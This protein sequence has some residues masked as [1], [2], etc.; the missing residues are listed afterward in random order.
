MGVSQQEA[1]LL[2]MMCEMGHTLGGDFATSIENIKQKILSPLSSSPYFVKIQKS[3]PFIKTDITNKLEGA[4]DTN[5]EVRV[6]YE[7]RESVRCIKPYKII[8]FEGFWYLYGV[9]KGVSE[10]AKLKLEK[11]KSC[12]I[13][14]KK[15][16][17]QKAILNRLEEATNIWFGIKPKTKVKLLI[18]ASEAKY[19]KVKQ[20]FP[21]QK[22]LKIRK[23]GDLEL[24][25]II[26]HSLELMPIIFSW[27]PYIKLISP[28][29]L[30]QQFISIVKKYI[31]QNK[32]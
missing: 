20:Y 28:Y 31:I 10:L 27:I 30:R 13:T 32:L 7:D 17:L 12:D 5:L 22:L 4:I 29:I 14:S 23:N 6:K 25:T 18:A 21:Y 19:F 3:T 8:N 1:S 26:N 11:I 24:E 15:F 16:K 2:V 9:E